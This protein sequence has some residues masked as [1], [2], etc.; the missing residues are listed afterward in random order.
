MVTWVRN[1]PDHTSHSVLHHGLIKLLITT[2]LETIDRSWQHF[3]FWLGFELESQTHDDE[4]EIRK[5]YIRHKR[6]VV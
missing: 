1:H 6:K 4:K 3:I 5:Q 2:K